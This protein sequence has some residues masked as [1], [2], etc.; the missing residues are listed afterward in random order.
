M[1]QHPPARLSGGAP[2]QLRCELE[3]IRMKRQLKRLFFPDFCFKEAEFRS[4]RI[5]SLAQESS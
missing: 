2:R 5:P 4:I 3:V 1:E